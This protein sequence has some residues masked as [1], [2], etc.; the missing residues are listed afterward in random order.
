MAL[1]SQ[2]GQFAAE[3]ESWSGFGCRSSVEKAYASVL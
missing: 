2:T 3:Q 1:P